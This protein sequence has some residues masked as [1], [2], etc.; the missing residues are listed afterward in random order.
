[1]TG[2][3]REQRT[4][5]E[6]LIGREHP[7]DAGTGVR[8]PYDVCTDEPVRA[9]PVRHADGLEF[10]RHRFEHRR[11]RLEEGAAQADI[12]HPAGANRG[13]PREEAD[14]NVGRLP[15]SPSLFHAGSRGGADVVSS[16]RYDQ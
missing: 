9:R 6:V 5:I 15:E 14:Q 13:T 4:H 11:A 1:L 8:P 7:F 16:S 2:K 12:E 10:D 3:Q